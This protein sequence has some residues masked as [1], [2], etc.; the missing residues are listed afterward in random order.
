MK[1]A[2]VSIVYFEYSLIESFL[3]WEY[4]AILIRPISSQLALSMI[5]IVVLGITKFDATLQFFC[6]GFY[7]ISNFVS[8]ANITLFAKLILGIAICTIIKMSGSGWKKGRKRAAT[9]QK[10]DRSY[11]YTGIS[12]R[13][14]S[15]A[16]N[17]INLY[18][19]S[20]KYKISKICDAAKIDNDIESDPYSLVS[21]V[22]VLHISNISLC[23][24]SVKTEFL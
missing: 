14:H 15:K 17:I 8:E 5:D 20:T 23:Y 19:H 12:Q 22:Q 3:K 4:Y 9:C 1:F 24:F 21:L 18:K 10:M 16:E 2:L 7:G 11:T 13:S 6:A